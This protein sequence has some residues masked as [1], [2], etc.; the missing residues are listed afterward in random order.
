ML[1]FNFV[2]MSK[3]YF[4]LFQAYYH[5]LPIPKQRRIKFRPSDKIEPQHIYFEGP[6]TKNSNII[7]ILKLASAKHHH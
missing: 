7:I 4:P 2:L 5:T 1:W 3:F 6:E